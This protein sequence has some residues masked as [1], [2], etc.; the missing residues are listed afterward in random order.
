MEDIDD[1]RP[2]RIA[3]L[4]L[5]DRPREKALAHGIK[6]LTAAELMAIILGGGIQGLSAIDL[7]KRIL[8]NNDNS[9]ADVSRMSIEEVCK[10]YRG[11][12][13]AKAI[14]L[15]AAFELGMRCRDEMTNP[16]DMVIRSSADAY[17]IMRSQLELLDHEEFWVLHLSRSNQVKSKVCI[18]RGGTA[19]TAVDIK[20][21]LK[22][23]LD[24]L[25]S[26]IILVHNH[27]SGNLKTSPQDD[28]LTS[29]IVQGAEYLD[30]KVLDHLIIARGGYFSYRDEGKI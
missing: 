11:V 9:L 24:S 18:S 7:A 20:L 5:D 19:S 13:P 8:Y 17:S 23:A 25:A 6:A 4:D 28:A 12:G 14:A 3:D 30:I 21:L 2:L 29:R 10:K 16:P 1:L 27:P 22:R 15:A 26:G